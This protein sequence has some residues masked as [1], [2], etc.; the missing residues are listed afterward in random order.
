VLYKI[1][2]TNT[3]K[4]LP[5][6]SVWLSSVAPK[7]ITPILPTHKINKECRDYSANKLYNSKQDR[8]RQYNVTLRRVRATI[9]AV[10]K[11]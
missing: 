4:T 1:D 5:C 8:Q 3:T 11:Q 2:C 6:F 7:P 9:V 10:E